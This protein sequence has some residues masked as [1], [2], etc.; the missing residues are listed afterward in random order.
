M[1]LVWEVWLLAET[2]IALQLPPSL[3]VGP[4]HVYARVCMYT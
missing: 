2:S 4:G 3:M 1:P